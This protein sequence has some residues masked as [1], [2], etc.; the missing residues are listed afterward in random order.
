MRDSVSNR[1]PADGGYACGDRTRERILTGAVSVFGECGYD[2]ASTRAIADRTRSNW[3]AIQYYFGSKEQLYK[4][5]AEHLADQVWSL[6][7]NRVARLDAVP[8]NAS[9]QAAADALCEFITHQTRMLFGAP[10][11]TAWVPFLARE[12]SAAVPGPAFEIIYERLTGPMTRSWSRLVGLAIG[13]PADAIET[14]L[15]TALIM[16]QTLSLRVHL[17]TLMRDL[18]WVDL[19]GGRLKYL[20]DVLEAHVRAALATPVSALL[21]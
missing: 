20:E 2:G 3:A 8:D 14:R 17:Q 1:R 10:E 11:T 12:Q 9:P 21:R 19:A 6:L 16:S 4:A 13:K 15:R 5:C 7:E 18:H